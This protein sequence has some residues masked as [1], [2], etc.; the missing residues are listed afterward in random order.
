MMLIE[1]VSIWAL[2]CFLVLVLA[3]LV[4]LG[5]YFLVFL[6]VGLHKPTGLIT[7]HFEP[8]SVIIA[9][10]NE[11]NNLEKNL[12]SILE[13]DYPIFEVIVV[14]D[15]SW[16]DSQKLLEYYQEVYP[17]LRIC[18]LVEQEKYPTGKKF[19]LTI[20]IKA[21]Q[22]Q[23][24]VFTDADCR[25]AGNQWLK[26]M[27]S[28]FNQHKEIVLGHSPY[29][30]KKGLLNLFVR[31]ENALTALFYFG[32]A[33]KNRPFMGVGRNLAYNKSLFF[34]HKGFASHQHI[35]SGDDDL[36][37]NQ[38]ATSN[39]VAIQLNPQSFIFT[40][41][42]STFDAYQRQKT[43]HMSTGKYY[44]LKDKLFLGGYYTALILFYPA[45]AAL[46][47]LQ[48]FWQVPTAVF[49]FKW[50]VQTVVFFIACKKLQYKNL[51]W[52]LLL[53]DVLYFWYIIVFGFKGLI[54]RKQK[55]W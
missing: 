40:D 11:Y 38:A 26:Y 16:D 17:H 41:A 24:L 29:A 23:Q 34:K 52:Y 54:T 6:K 47:F 55:V 19:A 42:K 9:A 43:R 4:L 31:F 45:L 30:A 44:K 33:L 5:Y 46:F 15:C 20:G 35:L 49:A 8:V 39:N 25:P 32:A 3:V 27:A 51:T 18:K 53:L 13:Q 37:V 2:V 48:P 21:S 10:R 22:Y 12:K 1:S 36:F 7:E 50:L 28:G 14:N